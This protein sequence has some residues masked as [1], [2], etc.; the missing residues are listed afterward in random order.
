MSYREEQTAADKALGR[1]FFKVESLHSQK[2]NLLKESAATEARMKE[3]NAEIQRASLEDQILIDQLAIHHGCTP[4][5]VHQ[6]HGC[7]D[8]GV[9]WIVVDGVNRLQR[10]DLTQVRGPTHVDWSDPYDS[11]NWSHSH[12]VIFGSYGRMFVNVDPDGGRV[13]Y[14]DHWEHDDQTDPKPGEAYAYADIIRFDLTNHARWNAAKPHGEVTSLT[15]AESLRLMTEG[16]RGIAQLYPP[17][18][19]L[20]IGEF[21]FWIIHS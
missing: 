2:S 6:M 19:E 14:V 18:T 15:E 7:G 3:L 4:D 11:A 9:V 10:V 8:F 16:A 20:D 13:G 12:M 17:E 5:A 21:N 1:Y